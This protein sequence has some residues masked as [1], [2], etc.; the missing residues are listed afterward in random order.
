M[1]RTIKKPIVI[2]LLS[3]CLVLLMITVIAYPAWLSFKRETIATLEKHQNF[4]LSHP[5]WSFPGKIYSAPASL[6]LPKKK[7]IAHAKIRNYT[8][9]CPARNPGEYCSDGTVVP[10]GGLFPEGEQPP[11]FEGWSRELAMEPVYLGPIIGTD[12]EIRE[13]LPIKEAPDKLIAAL[14]HSEDREF[15]KHS[16]VNFMAFGRAIIA[17]LQGRAYAQGASTITMQ[18]VRN[19]YQEKEKTVSRK[20]KEMARAMIIDSHLS[21]QEILQMYLDMPYMGQDGSYSICGFAAASKFY[22]NKDIRDTSLDEVA[23]LVGILPAPG[24]LRPDKHPDRAEAKRNR[25]LRIMSQHG[26]PVKESLDRPIPI[27]TNSLLNEY[28][29]ESYVQA[30][31]SWLEGTLDKSMI[32]G[33]GLQVHTAMDIVVQHETER[34]FE[35]K[36]DFF[37][38]E[39]GLPTNPPLQGAGVLIN[40][41]TGYLEAVY[42]GTIESPYDFSRA[43]QAKRQ[44]GS[45]FKP[46]VYAMAMSQ[47]NKNGLP[48]WKTFDT[49]P[50][51]RRTFPNTDGWRPRNNSN[52]YSET[53]TLANGLAWSQNVATATLLEKNG[54]PKELIAF[55]KEMGFDTSE[56]PEEM[57]LALGQ[58]EVTPLEMAKFSAMIANGGTKVHGIPVVAARDL[59]NK[60]HILQYPLGQRQLSDETAALIREMM[61][62][63]ISHGTGGSSRS[64]AGEKGYSGLAF[65]KTGTTDQNKDL[66]FI[67]STPTYT[68][69]VWLGYDQPYNL[70]ASS[71][72]LSAP[73]WGWWMRAVHTGMPLEKQFQG[74][75]LKRKYLCRQSGKYGNGSC[76]NIPIPLLPNQHPKGVCNTQHPAPDPLKPKY[77]NLW[78]RKATETKN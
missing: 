70:K 76:K 4:E 71:S 7:R 23:I 22:F 65:G 10:R 57:G 21:K 73:L 34:I 36:I 49:V 38:Q 9:N 55:A 19:L 54:G 41:K 72:D 68:G 44:A 39:L 35:D 56:F 45:S 43:T 63:V 77:Q 5:G 64:A 40:P 29:N 47:T 27:G 61:R 18:V 3:I 14:L 69:V 58:G 16:G 67:G 75:Q 53:S 78:K 2:V 13:H 1:M 12:A 50:N 15:F 37:M 42:G 25:V 46:L 11:G 28:R 20:L 59:G 30:T 26:W 8:L 48:M 52:E 62:L 33:S 51:L 74:M 66:W 60:N 32:Y 6:R 31:I 17:N 24:T